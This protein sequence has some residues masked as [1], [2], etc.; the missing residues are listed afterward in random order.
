MLLTLTKERS[1]RFF[2][3]LL[4]TTQILTRAFELLKEKKIDKF[5]SG[6]ISDIVNPNE[7]KY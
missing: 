1:A 6:T 7:E 3:S 5:D 2:G 4:Y